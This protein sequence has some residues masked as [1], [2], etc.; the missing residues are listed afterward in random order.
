MKRFCLE[1][2]YSLTVRRTLEL[3]NKDNLRH[4]PQRLL[5]QEEVEESQRQKIESRAEMIS[6]KLSKEYTVNLHFFFQRQD[7]YFFKDMRE[8]SMED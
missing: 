7:S 3:E 6:W 5:T 8:M 2:I 4:L 1:K